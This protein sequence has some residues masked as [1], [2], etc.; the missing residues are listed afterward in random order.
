MNTVTTAPQPQ[1]PAGITKTPNQACFS[2]DEAALAQALDSQLGQPG[3][4]AL[5]RECCPTCSLRGRCSWRCLPI[6]RTAQCVRLLSWSKSC[7]RAK[8]CG[9]WASLPQLRGRPRPASVRAE[10][11]RGGRSRPETPRYGADT[12]TRQHHTHQVARFVTAISIPRKPKDIDDPTPP[13]DSAN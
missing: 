4:S 9:R 11:D 12:A 13:D 1:W 10:R 7:K 6:V 8:A 5:V 3:L 2:L